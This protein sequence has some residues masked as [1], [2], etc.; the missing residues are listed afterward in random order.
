MRFDIPDLRLFLAVAEAGSIT[1]G[2]AAVNL[3][4]PAASERLRD[5][6]ALG[7]VSLIQRG[8]RGV[9]LT[10]AGEALVS[11]ARIILR[12]VSDMHDELAEHARGIRGTVR[13]L[14]NTAAITEFLPAKLGAWLA[15]HPKVDINLTERPSAD[16]IKGVAGG[17]ADF[18]IV[19]DAV[20][21]GELKCLPLTLDRLVVVMPR[22]HALAG[23]RQIALAQ[24]L[25]EDFV[26]FAGALQDHI[27]EHAARAG[28]RLRPRV[29]LRT[30]ESICRTVAD[31]G[32]IG[33]VPQTAASRYRRSIPIATSQLNDTWASRRLLA[34]SRDHAELSPAA[35]GFLVHLSSR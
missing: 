17:V 5:M 22:G 29:R 28:R 13:L 26:G 30:F 10:R 6:E 14:A 24:V 35:R 25:G 34:V 32:G 33:I 19:S 8:R 23:A 27:E 18:G 12:H 11:H 31:G 2:A 4:L 9:T 3:S 15:E 1:H 16:I 21:R 7:E 20:D